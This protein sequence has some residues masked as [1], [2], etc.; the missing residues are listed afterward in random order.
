MPLQISEKIC[1]QSALSKSLDKHEVASVNPAW[2]KDPSKVSGWNSPYQGC[3]TVIQ[4]FWSG[5]AQRV[6]LVRVLVTDGKCVGYRYAKADPYM[7]PS[8]VGQASR[9]LQGDADCPSISFSDKVQCR[10]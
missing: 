6:L 10:T 2:S 1:L 3:F 5:S 8:V 4:T 7:I 9:P